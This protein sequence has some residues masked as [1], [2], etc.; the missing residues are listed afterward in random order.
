MLRFLNLGDI[1]VDPVLLAVIG[2]L[3]IGYPIAIT[4]PA[5]ADVRFLG[6]QFGVFDYSIL[7]S[8]PSRYLGSMTNEVLVAVPLFIFMGLVLERSGIAEALLTTMGQLFGKLRGGLAYL[9]HPRWRAAC[10]LD[11]RRRRD[12]SDNG[13]DLPPGDDAGRLRPT[14]PHRHHLRVGD[15]GADHPAVDRA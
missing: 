13:P 3:L 5:I 1:L 6:H 14:V 8:L 4:L 15:D 10:R 9:G 11:R 12:R 7:N 2:T